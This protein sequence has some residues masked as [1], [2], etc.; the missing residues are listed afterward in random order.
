MYLPY[1]IL[2]VMRSLILLI[3][4]LG[5][6]A[7]CVGRFLGAN[8]DVAQVPPIA[9][10]TPTQAL[11]PLSADKLFSLVNKWRADNGYQPYEKSDKLCA[12][13]KD[14]ALN[15]PPLDDHKGFLAKYN[16]LPYVLSENLVT[17]ESE[18]MALAGWL[19]S[20]SH[21]AALEKPYRYSCIY[22]KD[23]YCVHIFSSFERT[24]E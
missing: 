21:R 9:T 18:P 6:A 2:E 17:A 5:V 24:D 3:T 10:A 20:A 23:F 14:R 4:I 19:G 12:I 16:S 7:F 11:R 15:D 1:A 8:Q 13:A 22:C